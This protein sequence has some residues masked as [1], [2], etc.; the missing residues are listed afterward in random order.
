MLGRQRLPDVH[1]PL[2]MA[3]DPAAV[4]VT[5]PPDNVGFNGLFAM[6]VVSDE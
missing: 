5:L 3:T 1:S 6:A 2:M 4:R